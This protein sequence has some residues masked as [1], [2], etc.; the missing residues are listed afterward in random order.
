MFVPEYLEQMRKLGCL[1]QGANALGAKRFLHL[2]ALFIH[3]H[4]L[5]IGQKLAIGRPQGEGTVVAERGRFTAVS[6]FSH[7]EFQFLSYIIPLRSSAVFYHTSTY[8][9]RK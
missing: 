9:S 1:D 7:D 3:S 6:T 8:T 4:L 2:A 5:Q